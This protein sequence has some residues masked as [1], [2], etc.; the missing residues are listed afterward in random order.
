MGHVLDPRCRQCNSALGT[1]THSP[2]EGRHWATECPAEGRHGLH[3]ARE[4][5]PKAGTGLHW[6]TACRPQARPGHGVPGRRPALACSG[7]R[8]ARPKAGPPVPVRHCLHLGSRFT[9]CSGW[10]SSPASTG[11]SSPHSEPASKPA[12]KITTVRD[13]SSF[14]ILSSLI[15]FF[16]GTSRAP[17]T[18]PSCRRRMIGGPPPGVL[19]GRNLQIEKVAQG[20]AA[21]ITKN[22]PLWARRR[23]SE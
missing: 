22:S 11:F 23:R 7:A 9:R 12:R 16:C 21:H 6:G 14:E 17:M 5:R 4:C 10:S 20:G 19:V 8:S 13:V 2:A 1:G 3:W 18:C 15:R